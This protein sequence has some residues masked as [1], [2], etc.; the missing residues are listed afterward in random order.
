MGEGGGMG[1]GGGTDGSRS[2][3]FD[4]V[5]G[6]NCKSTWPTFNYTVRNSLTEPQFESTITLAFNRGPLMRQMERA[7]QINSVD[8]QR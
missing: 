1:G 2:R 4:C 5:Y 8:F 6:I 7:A 3:Q